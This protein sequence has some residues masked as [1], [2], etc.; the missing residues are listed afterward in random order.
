[1]DTDTPAV[2]DLALNVPANASVGTY[3]ST[4]T[5]TLTPVTV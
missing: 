1:M 3:T 4:I 2:A 5:S